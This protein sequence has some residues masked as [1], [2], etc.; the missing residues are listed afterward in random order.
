MQIRTNEDA[1]LY[2]LERHPWVLEGFDGKTS[3]AVVEQC[4]RCGGA[5]YYPTPSHGPCFHCGG[6]PELMRETRLVTLKGTA[7]RL[8]RAD[9]SQ[10]RRQAKAAKASELAA[11]ASREFLAAR[12]D[13]SAILAAGAG[14]RIL[15]DLAAKLARFGKLSEAQVSLALA[16][17]ADLKARDAEMKVCAPEGRT[18]FEGEV[19]SQKFKETQYGISYRITVKVTTESGV[20]FANGNAPKALIQ[21]TWDAVEQEPFLQGKKVRMTANLTQSDTDQHFAFYKRP[22]KSSLVG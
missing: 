16:I 18:E 10:A 17:G 22:T 20:W 15:G 13:L 21:K 4:R 19:I 11:R 1:R 14:H 3:Y 5:G 2:L 7:Q 6:R 12:P 8:K 9:D